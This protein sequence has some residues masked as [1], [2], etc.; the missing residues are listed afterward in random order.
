V[1][2]KRNKPR[3]QT[4][5]SQST[6]EDGT[7][8]LKATEP[9]G[10]EHLEKMVA[11]LMVDKVPKEHVGIEHDGVTEETYDRTTM[12]SVR[13]LPIAWGMPF[14][15]LTFS[16]W[17]INMYLHHR[18]MPWDDVVVARSTYLPDA[19]N[20]V[21][22]NFVNKSKCEWLF[23]LDTDVLPPPGIIERFLEHA[24]SGKKMIGGWYRKKGEPYLPVVYDYRFQAEGDGIHLW[25]PRE[26]PGTGVESV[27]GAGAGCWF[28][29]REVAEALGNKPYD[30]EHGG[31]DL[32]LCK[33]VSEIGYKMWIDWDMACAHIGVATV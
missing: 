27:D 5:V 8:V 3:K 24:K 19:R 10:R 17:I 1:V 15:E 31:E 21:H 23:M 30:M 11:E 29:H 7:L 20:M 2:G 12:T 16:K 25:D 26:Q 14:D 4:Y 9:A 32:V 33:K 28:M 18:P 13:T 22:N 6:L